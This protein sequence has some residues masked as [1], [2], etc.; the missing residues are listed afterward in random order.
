MTDP[1]KAKIIELCP[2]IMIL[3]EMTRF[4]GFHHYYQPRT[5]EIMRCMKKDGCISCDA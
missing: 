1:I 2:D 5:L 3:N 4:A